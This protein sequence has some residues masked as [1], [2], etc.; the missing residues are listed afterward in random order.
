M[1]ALLDIIGPLRAIL[2][3]LLGIL[4]KLFRVSGMF[5]KIAGEQAG[6]LDDISGTVAPYDKFVCLGPRNSR[7]F[8]QEVKRK[9][10]TTTHPIHML[11]SLFDV[12]PQ[13]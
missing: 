4:L 5:Y 11:S 13:D 10:G 6:L 9:F 2:A 7:A 12:L 8:V 3:A 1:Q